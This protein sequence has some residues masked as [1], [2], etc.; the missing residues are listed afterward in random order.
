[1]IVEVVVVRRRGSRLPL[2]SIAEPSP[3]LLSWMLRSGVDASAH[4]CR[5][6][7]LLNGQQVTVECRLDCGYRV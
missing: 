6:E 4:F 3:P 7:G 5:N 2:R 1:M